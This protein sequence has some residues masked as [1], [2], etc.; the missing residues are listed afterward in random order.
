[1][2]KYDH[3]HI[4][5][6]NSGILEKNN[7]YFVVLVVKIFS[8]VDLECLFNIVLNQRQVLK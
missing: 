1:M 4:K 7:I 6:T 5:D 3:K 8:I 2:P